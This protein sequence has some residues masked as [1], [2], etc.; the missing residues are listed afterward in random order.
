MLLLLWVSS[1]LCFLCEYVATTLSHVNF[2]LFPLGNKCKWDQ[3]NLTLHYYSVQGTVVTPSSVFIKKL[4]VI[5]I[6]MTVY[7][8][9]KQ[10]ISSLPSVI[11][12][13]VTSII[14][15]GSNMSNQYW[16]PFILIMTQTLKAIT[17]LYLRPQIDTS[18]IKESDVTLK[19]VC[20]WNRLTYLII[21]NKS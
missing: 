20:D 2:H 4:C 13:G 12:G 9:G 16:N 15:A 7:T 5:I 18:L 1:L 3:L 11:T 21:T 19:Q 10:N 6:S 14:Q 8:Y 17:Q